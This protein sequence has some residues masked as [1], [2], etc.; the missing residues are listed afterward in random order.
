MFVGKKYG[1][2]FRLGDKLKIQV[3]NADIE[4]RQVDFVVF[5]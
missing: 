2:R 5:M 3:K 4:R 1:K